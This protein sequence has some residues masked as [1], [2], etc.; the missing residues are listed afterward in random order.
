MDQGSAEKLEWLC[1]TPAFREIGPFEYHL[2][3]INCRGLECWHIWRG[4]DPRQSRLIEP[5]RA[6][7]PFHCHDCQPGFFWEKCLVKEKRE[8]AHGHAVAQRNRIQPDERA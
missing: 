8:F 5:F 3:R 4:K 6:T 2:S 7:P 1:C